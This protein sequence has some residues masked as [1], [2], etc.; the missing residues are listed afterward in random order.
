MIDSRLQQHREQLVKATVVHREVAGDVRLGHTQL[1][2]AYDLAEKVAVDD[3]DKDRPATV[4]DD[5][6]R[7]LRVELDLSMGEMFFQRI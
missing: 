4:A 5:E 3:L 1:A 7:G 6:F 2:A